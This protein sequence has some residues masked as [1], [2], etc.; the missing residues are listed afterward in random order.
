MQRIVYIST[1]TRPLEDGELVDLLLQC[2]RN[3][4]R[5]GITGM[6]LYKDG[7]FVQALEGP[8]FA[9]RACFERIRRDERHQD[10]S[11]LVD[12]AIRERTFSD[13]SMGFRSVTAADLAIH[14]TLRALTSREHVEYYLGDSATVVRAIGAFRETADAGS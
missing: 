4:D 2:R 5:D 9:V 11:V 8:R 7:V 3:N 6:L 14:P 13:W 1:A 12:Q 10:L